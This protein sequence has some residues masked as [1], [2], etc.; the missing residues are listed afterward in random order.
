MRTRVDFGFWKN[1]Y[2]DGSHF[3]GVLLFEMLLYESRYEVAAEMEMV[4]FRWLENADIDEQLQVFP[5]VVFSGK[6][7][8]ER[9][10]AAA[11]SSGVEVQVV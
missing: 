11:G 8:A 9:M 2:G 3:N 1:L 4:Q 6:W 7:F 5:G 10:V